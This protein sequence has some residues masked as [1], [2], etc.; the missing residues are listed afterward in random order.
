MLS[1]AARYMLAALQVILGWEWIV[2][3]INKVLSG[4]F[5]QQLDSTLQGGFQDNPNSWYI[6]FLKAFVMPHGVFFGYLIEWTE[7]ITGL[8]LLAGAII[9]LSSPRLRE[10]AQHKLAVGICT[11]VIFAAIA[12][13]LMTINYHFWIGK[14]IIPGMSADPG[15][16]AIDLEALVPPLSLIIIAAQMAY[17]KALRGETWY[18]RAYAEVKLRLRRFI[19]MEDE[20][21]K[22]TAS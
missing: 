18:S 5:P 20:L 14:S 8:A 9:V 2:S 19:G 10:D 11:L 7:V 22:E 21:V 6:G 1:K 15:D 3:G 17:I 16:E 13:S 4:T 12:G